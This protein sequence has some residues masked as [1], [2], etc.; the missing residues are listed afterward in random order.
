MTPGSP[1]AVE[2]G[3]TCA[4]GDNHNGAGFPWGDDICFWISADCPIHGEEDG[5]YEAAL[6]RLTNE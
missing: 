4:I 5:P 6:G 1:E 2:A 3:C